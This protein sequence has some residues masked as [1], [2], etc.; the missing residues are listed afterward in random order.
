MGGRRIKL[1]WD[2]RGPD[3]SQTAAH[4]ELHLKEFSMAS[5][6]EGGETGHVNHSEFH[7]SAFL[8]VEEA[9]MIAV[10]DKLLPHRGE[11]IS[12]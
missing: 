9:K 5:D 3:A 2:F 7:S 10:R 4:H 8:V 6:G 11:Y 12:A 1:I